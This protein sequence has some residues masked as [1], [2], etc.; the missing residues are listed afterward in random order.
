[1]SH[2][3]RIAIHSHEYKQDQLSCLAFENNYYITTRTAGGTYPLR[4]LDL[5]KLVIRYNHYA[6]QSREYFFGVKAT[7]GD[8]HHEDRNH[9]RDDN[10]FK[11]A[12]YNEIIDLTLKN[13]KKKRPTKAK[14]GKVMAK[15]E[16]AS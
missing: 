4:E 15:I 13:K 12:D 7:R 5:Q 1:M 9:Y 8:V 11:R 10:Y 3:K 6:V 2:L 16:E 14:A